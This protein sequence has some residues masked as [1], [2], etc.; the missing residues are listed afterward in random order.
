MD[1][2]YMTAPRGGFF[3]TDGQWA[4]EG[5]GIAPDIEVFMEP[6][7]VI[8]GKDPQL[9][10]AVAE[11]LRLLPTQGIEFKKEPPPPVKYKRPETK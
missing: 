1:G 3:D 9:E 2:G 10:K 6:K 5:K 4:V 7:D 11:A 8:E